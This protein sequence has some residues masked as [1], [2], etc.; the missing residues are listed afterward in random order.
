MSPVTKMASILPT[1]IRVG[2]TGA[3]AIR[4]SVPPDRS[5][6]SERM[7]RPPPMKRKMTAMEGA[8]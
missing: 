5:S 1:T 8:K 6:I 7:P 3:A 4:T 2:R